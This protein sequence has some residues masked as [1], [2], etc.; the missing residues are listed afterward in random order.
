MKTRS[1]ARVLLGVVALLSV[2]SAVAQMTKDIGRKYDIANEVR[3][4][5][6][7]QDVRDVPGNFEGIRLVVSTGATTVMVRVAPAAFLKD[8][9]ASFKTGDQV[10]IVGSRVPNSSDE[11]FLAR[12]ITVGNNTITLRDDQGIPVWAGWNPSSVVK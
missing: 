6:V 10:V 8:I 2:I 9:D 1:W 11:E 3:I 5:G 7:V 4:K 12:E